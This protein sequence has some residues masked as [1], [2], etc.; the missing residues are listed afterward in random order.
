MTKNRDYFNQSINTSEEAQAF[1]VRMYLTGDFFHP[2]NSP[3]EIIIDV[4]G[5]DVPLFSQKESKQLEYRL[6]EIH[7]LLHDPCEFM[8]NY[9]EKLSQQNK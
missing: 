7:T 3:Y 5:Q 4:D 1:L 2:E 9:M 8:L 6:E